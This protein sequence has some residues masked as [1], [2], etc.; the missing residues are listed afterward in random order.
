MVSPLMERSAAGVAFEGGRHRCGFAGGTSAR[1]TVLVATLV[2]ALVASGRIAPAETPSHGV[3]KVIELFT[4]QGCP[5]C[6][7]ADRLISD[8]ARQSDTVALSYPVNY[9]DYAGWH[10]T[11]A[12]PAFTQRQHAYA[13]ARGDRLVFTPQAI[14]DGLVVE[15]GADK[16][17]ILH[18]TSALS[19][20]ALV[21]PLDLT[22]S[23]GTLHIRLGAGSS[24]AGESGSVYVLRVARDKTVQIDRGANSGRS[25]TYT[26]VVRAMTRIGAWSGTPES[27]SLVELN[28][29]DEGYVVLLQAGTPEKPGAILGAAK[30]AGL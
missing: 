8:L 15:P 10:D 27:F 24:A 19:G 2:A 4:S 23:G 6:P 22:E 28:A 25:V 3:S 18:A 16:T 20:S 29:D 26:N 7:P 21:V 30:T 11:L 5:K 14:V 17:A 12:S 13:A 1:L 9:W